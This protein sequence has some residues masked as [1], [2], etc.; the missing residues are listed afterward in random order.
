MT[1][2]N[3]DPIEAI[4]EQ[5]VLPVLRSASASDALQR[6][7]VLI[8]AGAPVVEFTTSIP[9][10]EKALS[11]A[12]RQ[13]TDGIIG[14]GT[15]GSREQAE[16]AVAAGARFLVSPYAAPDVRAVAVAAGVPFIQ[17]GL[18]PSELSSS[19]V[20]GIAKVFP[21]HVGGPAYLRSLRPVLPGVKLIPTGGVA[22]ADVR[23]YLAAGAIAVGV[24]SGLPEDFRPLA[25][26]LRKIRLDEV[27]KRVKS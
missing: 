21:A 5:R 26:T 24:G 17:G 16:R 10:W 9:D 18:T 20:D 2:A 25:D 27:V 12:S 1:T 14:I 7:E 15:V 4:S 3:T 13:L 6:A 23:A 19:V 8:S 11:D 22:L